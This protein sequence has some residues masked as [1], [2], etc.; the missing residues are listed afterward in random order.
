MQRVLDAVL[1]RLQGHTP[2]ALE[3]YLYLLAVLHEDMHG[4]ALTYM[5]QTLAYPAPQL[6][7]MATASAPC[8]AGQWAMPWG[9]HDPRRDI[10]FRGHAGSALCV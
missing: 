2:S 9:C 3:T 7:S 1:E 5:R 10:F 4:E 8:S 6:E